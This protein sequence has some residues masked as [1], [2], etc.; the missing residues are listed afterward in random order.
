MANLAFFFKVGA[1][2]PGRPLGFRPLLCFGSPGPPVPQKEPPELTLL[3]GEVGTSREVGPL[4]KAQICQFCRPPSPH[5]SNTKRGITPPFAERPLG[6]WP[7]VG[8]SE[9]S[10]H[11]R[12][13]QA[14]GGE[15]FFSRA[16]L[17]PPPASWP[18]AQGSHLG[19]TQPPL[20]SGKSS[21]PFFS[22]DQTGFG[23]FRNIPQLNVVI[24]RFSFG[25]QK[26]KLIALTEGFFWKHSL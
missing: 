7:R 3:P 25:R 9:H 13:R 18:V 8:R 20:G 17:L 15:V 1:P 6:N 2:D 14:R 10:M 23:R 4:S 11:I 16:I 22:P 21:L 5:Q 19:Q 12:S 26:V 24:S